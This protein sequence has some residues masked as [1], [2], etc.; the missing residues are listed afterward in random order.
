MYHFSYIRYFHAVVKTSSIRGAAE[1][2]HVA[3]SAVSRQI[4]NLEA[5]LG[6][7]LFDRHARGV[8]LTDAG[9]ILARYA[10]QTILDLDRARSEIDDLRALRRGTVKI[11]S[12]EAAVTDMVPTVVHQFRAQHP[13]IKFNITVRGTQG[14]VDALLKDDADVGLAFNTPRHPEIRVIARQEQQ[15]NAVMAPDHP[16]AHLKQIKMADL[17]E[18]P[19]GLPDAS[20][21]IR[22]LVDEI[23]GYAEREEDVLQTNS[24]QALVHFARLGMGIV[25]LPFFA[26]R[27]ELLEKQL[28]AVPLADRK[29]RHASV[30]LIV[31]AGRRLPIAVE[32]F[33]TVMQG[34]LKVLR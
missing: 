26:I 22:K 30:E 3:Q 28:V 8:R 32:E 33:L 17:A 2:L 13:S 15:L 1:S 9:E 25:F 12:V 24:I 21:G 10:Q 4:K 7:E 29:A 6:V 11:C 27:R 31:H 19:I 5:T 14:V 16:L 23:R 18:L 20:F 34:T